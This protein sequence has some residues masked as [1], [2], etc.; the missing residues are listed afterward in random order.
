MK[1]APSNT[2]KLDE[3][4]NRPENRK[5]FDCHEKVRKRIE[6]KVI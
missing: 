5:C 3:L 4:K 1:A 2:A 6:L